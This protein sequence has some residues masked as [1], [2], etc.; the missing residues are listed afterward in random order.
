MLGA[1]PPAREPSEAKPYPHH[2]RNRKG[3]GARSNQGMHAREDVQ[4]TK[5]CDLERAIPRESLILAV[6]LW[7]LDTSHEYHSQWE[8]L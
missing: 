6:V 1:K 4:R 7:V 2:G 5:V 3:K 8:E